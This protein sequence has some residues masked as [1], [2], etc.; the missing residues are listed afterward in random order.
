MVT[1]IFLEITNNKSI[2]RQYN[3]FYKYIRNNITVKSGT[4]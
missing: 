3:I 1:R 4:M 2:F